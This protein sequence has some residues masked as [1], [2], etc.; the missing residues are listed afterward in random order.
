VQVAVKRLKKELYDSKDDT[1]LF[2]QEVQLMRKLRHRC[3]T[4]HHIHLL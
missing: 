2:G 1:Q 3:E 4:G